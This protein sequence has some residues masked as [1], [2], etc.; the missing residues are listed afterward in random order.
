MTLANENSFDMRRGET[1]GQGVFTFAS[2]EPGSYTLRVE[3]SGFKAFLKSGISISPS[4]TCGMDVILEVGAPTETVTITENASQMQTETGAKQETLHSKEIDNLSIISRSSLELLRILPGVSAPDNADL[5]TISFTSGANAIGGYIVNGVRGENNNLSIDGSRL[6]DFGSNRTVMVTP[7]NDMVHEV[8]VQTSN[9][10]AEFGSS[11]VQITATTKSGGSTFH[12]SAYDYV[13][14]WHL[15]AA[16]RSRTLFGIERPQDKYQY[17][18]GNIGGPVCLPNFGE[19]KLFGKCYRNRLFFFFGLEIQRQEIDSGAVFGRVPT[20]AERQGHFTIDGQR[21][22]LSDRIDPIGQAF[23]NFY[24]FPNFLSPNGVNANSNYTFADLHPIN[25]NQQILRLDYDPSEKTRLYV[26]LIREGE[27]ENSARGLWGGSTAFELPSHVLGTNR[28]RSIALNVTSLIS[29]TMTNEILFSASKLRLD[30]DYENPSK[31]TLDDLGISNYR[32]PFGQQSAYAPI[33]FVTS[34]SGQTSGDLFTLGGEPVFAHNSNYSLINNLTKISKAHTL[35]FGGMVEQGN[36]LQKSPGFPEGLLVYAPW[37]ANSTGDVFGDILVGRPALVFQQ[38]QIPTGDF[39]FYTFEGFAQDSWKIRPNLSLEYGA[40]IAYFRNNVERNGLGMLFDPAT[41]DHSQGL[42]LNNNPARPN[43]I[44]LAQRGEIPKG[45]TRN[46]TPQ[47]MPRFGF[48]WDIG[49]K[50]KTVIRGGAG[51]FYNRVQGNFQYFSALQPP[52]TYSANFDASAFTDLSGGAGLTYQTMSLI[53]PYEQL[54]AVAITSLNPE[55]SFI[56]RIATI[57]LSFGQ[58]LPLNNILEVSYV[59]TLG[60]HLPQRREINF[61]PQ[62]RLLNRVLAP[63]SENPA[64]L[65]NPITR[66]AVAD[67]GSV[68]AQFRTFPAYSSVVYL[69]YAGTSSYHSLQATLKRQLAK[70]LTYFAAYSFSK[71]LGT[72]ATDEN[73]DTVD[74][75]DTR[76]RSYGVL[77]YDRTH[78]F[79][80][81]YSYELPNL[82]PGG[83]ANSVTRGLL[84]GW[85]MSG[86]TTFQSGAPIKLRFDG[87]ISR[88]NAALAFFGTDAFSSTPNSSGAIAPIF[89]KNPVVANH[90]N[91]GD[92]VFD[93]NA[94]AIPNFGTSGPSVASY[95]LRGPARSNFDVTLFKNFNFTETRKVQLRAAFFN[96]F[97]QAF[98]IYIEGDPTNSDI[99]TSLNATCLVRRDNVPNGTGGTSNNV[100]DPTG[101]FTF[102][103]DTVD[104]FGKI[105]R[106]HGHRIV[107]LA[108]KFYF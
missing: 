37:H 91:L 63:D 19:G 59:G 31:V 18:G 84:N 78:V 53:N 6:I 27:D 108:V 94:I 89:L 2:I 35:K 39:R 106:K 33:A 55:S 14:N 41:Y 1:S 68:L 49:G 60:R 56:P 32:G 79:N 10:A 22:D 52:N 54:G 51:L 21:V 85:Q 82:A 36:K 71:A 23:I 104:N 86:I 95:Y 44:L 48:A 72:S 13:R 83:F 70:G 98:P 67:Q 97:N 8:K 96:V 29:P 57:S 101:G 76:G 107:E 20:V 99:N 74:P 26:R 16:D 50:A 66:M 34:P 11:A 100:C 3:A 105:T 61:I 62:G 45:M 58:R 88:P 77:G 28:A 47:F 12:G 9:F 5:Q 46:P 90:K 102:T 30:N 81:S 65:S 69:E 4:D 92:R 40:R 75:I 25:R 93:L 87:E 43:G 64:D 17:P 80:L 7:N 15:N 38:T 42:L 73:N 103:Q 24:P